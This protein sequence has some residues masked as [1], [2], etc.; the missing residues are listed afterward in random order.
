MVLGR[1]IHAFASSQCF[2]HRLAAQKTHLGVRGFR[3][4]TRSHQRWT[5][6][7]VVSGL[8]SNDAHRYATLWQKQ[9]DFALYLLLPVVAAVGLS[10]ASLYPFTARLLAF[11]IPFLSSSQ[12]LP[13]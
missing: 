12:Q 9:R 2:R 6:L 1:R 5:E 3:T 10:A 13:D 8:C 4:G 7:S 11:L